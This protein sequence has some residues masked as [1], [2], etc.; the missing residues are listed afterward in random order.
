MQKVL[1]VEDHAMMLDGLI[2]V[3]S[4][5]DRIE[6]VDT[7]ES[8]EAF[9]EL[10]E[11]TEASLIIADYQLKD[12]VGTE[13]P[14]RLETHGKSIP[15]LLMSGVA[16]ERLLD[17]A[18]DAGCCGYIPKS[19][20]SKDLIGAVLAVADGGSIFPLEAVSHRSTGSDRLGLTDRESE[21]LSLLA[22]AMNAQ[23]IAVE[24]DV[25]VA[26]IRN[27]IRSILIK[28]GARSQL[29]AVLTAFKLRLV[30]PPLR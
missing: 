17:L 7:A 11:S 19:M 12:G 16:S 30:D 1:L 18:I 20:R 10:V 6:V 5:D 23:K 3:F 26:T 27:H 2:A 15:V 4:L 8:I 9:E 25:S 21:V 22:T 24:L 14:R 13:I 28:L 29:E